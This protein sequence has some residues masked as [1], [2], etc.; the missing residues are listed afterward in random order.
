M[1]D[2]TPIKTDRPDITSYIKEMLRGAPKH[3]LYLIPVYFIIFYALIVTGYFPYIKEFKNLHFALVVILLVIP[4]ALV[5]MRFFM[6]EKRKLILFYLYTAFFLIIQVMVQSTGGLSSPLYA[7]LY[8]MIMLYLAT[9]SLKNTLFFLTLAIAGESIMVSRMPA[10]SENLFKFHTHNFFYL[11]FFTIFYFTFLHENK[12]KDRYRL[13]LKTYEGLDDD[14][15]DINTK[16]EVD[17]TA[18]SEQGRA[19]HKIH[20]TQKLNDKIYEILYKIKDIIHPFTIMYLEIDI[21]EGKFFI[22]EVI[23][24]SDYI[25]YNLD[26]NTNWG[27]PGWIMKNK[28]ALSV[29]NFDNVIPELFYYT[30]DELIKSLVMVPAMEDDNV[31]GILLAD[32]RELQYFTNK[33]ESLL[34]LAAYQ[35]MQEIRNYNIVREV[36]YNAK[37]SSVLNQLGKR[38][39]ASLDLSDTIHVMISAIDDLV[40]CELIAVVFNTDD[41]KLCRINAVRGEKFEGLVGKEFKKDEGICSYV[42]SRKRKIFFKD[43]SLVAEKKRVFDRSVKIKDMQTVFILPLISKDTAFGAVL[44]AYRQQA[45]M[46]SH[47]ISTIETLVNQSASSIANAKMYLKVE[48]MATTD[49]LTGLFNH[50]CFQERINEEMERVERY[51]EKLSILLMDI[52]HFKK[53]NDTYGHPVGDK[54]LKTAASIFQSSLRKVD[55]AARYGGEEFVAILINTDKKGAIKM[56]ER[57]RK[58]IARKQV[59]ISKEKVS[60]SV[61]IGLATYPDNSKDKK[62]IINLA[63]KALYFAKETGRN[64]CVHYSDI[65]DDDTSS[66]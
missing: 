52:D 21:A 59:E 39:N 27:Y 12:Q 30:A 35:I 38:L 65:T 28:R 41:D 16:E 60:I 20:V 32:S 47:T 4:I 37:E 64:R 19:R 29:S 6:T 43:L 33:E 8:L 62:G 58:N 57:I 54:V 56:G 9:S 11:V 14:T 63:D 55:F 66:G 48:R 23:S 1:Y 44:I 5:F 3:I 2:H 36:E 34:S 45:A 18:L 13:L 51:P 24:E 15:R 17:V 53:F 40:N 26:V 31:K 46:T 50:R 42:I 61:S 22:K 25:N 49:G 10:L 7:L